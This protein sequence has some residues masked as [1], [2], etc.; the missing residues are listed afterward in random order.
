MGDLRDFARRTVSVLRWRSNHLG[1]HN[2]FSSRG[3]YWSSD[4]SFWHPAPDGL[5]A[6]LWAVEP[7]SISGEVYNDTKQIVIN[8]GTEPLPHDLIREAL[9]QRHSNPRSAMVLGMAAAELAVKHCVGVLVPQ[10]EWLAMN[11]LTP[12]LV[13]MLREY[14][15]KLPV[16]CRIGDQVKAP[17]ESVMALL[18]K[19][20]DIRNGLAHA[21]AAAPPIHDVEE[22][23]DAVRDLLWLL[24]YY[25]G[26]E[27]ALGFVRS[28]T[29]KELGAA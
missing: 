24:D 22:I 7:V 20:S 9:D 12:P 11:L 14:V 23:L 15:P 10:A 5:R 19:G 26:Y 16:R 27:W 29:R 2:P 3:M 4:G 17:P 13:K 6:R 18:K 1:P 21:G 28:S 25:A 8:G